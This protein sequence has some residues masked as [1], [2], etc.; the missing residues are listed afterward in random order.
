MKPDEIKVEISGGLANQIFM[1]LGGMWLADQEAKKLNL[2]HFPSSIHSESLKDFKLPIKVSRYKKSK[3]FLIRILRKLSKANRY[4]ENLISKFGFIFLKEIGFPR[5]NF[6]DRKVKYFSGYCQSYLIHKK[7][8]HGN[9]V[10]EL[11]RYEPNNWT[12]NYVENSIGEKDIA[13][14]VRLGDYEDEKNSIGL[15]G[16]DYYRESLKIARAEGGTGKIRVLTND[17]AECQNFFISIPYNIEYV[18]TPKYVPNFDSLYILSKHKF[19]ILSNSSFSLLAGLESEAKTV[20]RPNP[21]FKNIEEPERLSPDTWISVPSS[22][23]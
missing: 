20:I 9:S 1:F 15:V 11:L 7:A 13:I 14:H 19:L 18:K 3:S 21:W 16:L 10:F 12:R 8:L 2:I 6:A 17:I 4:F 22:W 23:R 5:M